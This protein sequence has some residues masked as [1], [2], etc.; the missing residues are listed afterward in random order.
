[1]YILLQMVYDYFGTCFYIRIQILSL[2]LC[3]SLYVCVSGNSV[4]RPAARSDDLVKDPGGVRSAGDRI[5]WCV[6]EEVFIQQR[7]EIG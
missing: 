1:M 3:M 7:V 5:E 2:K 6:L 4:G